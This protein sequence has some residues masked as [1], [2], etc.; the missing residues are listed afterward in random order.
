MIVLNNTGSFGLPISVF[1]NPRPYFTC[2]I[3]TSPTLITHTLI[4]QY[5]LKH[6]YLTQSIEPLHKH[7]IH[8]QNIANSVIFTVGELF[9]GTNN[10]LLI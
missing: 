7:D 2:C 5:R 4:G 3:V 9:K 1:C 8:S 10:N 6:Y